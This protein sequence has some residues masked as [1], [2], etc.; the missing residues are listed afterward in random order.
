MSRVICAVQ[1]AA[2]NVSTTSVECAGSHCSSSL[3]MRSGRSGTVS[4]LRS[5]SHSAQ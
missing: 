3:Q 1:M 4:E 5:G 2:W